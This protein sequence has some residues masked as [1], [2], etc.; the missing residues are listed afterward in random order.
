MKH[1]DLRRIDLNLLVTFDALM[2]TRS[3]TRAAERLGLGQPAVSHALA[4]LRD[5]TG[6]SLFVSSRQGLVPTSRALSIAGWVRSVLEDAQQKLL[7]PAPFNPAEWAGTV[8][9]SMTPKMD[10]LLMPRLLAQLAVQAPHVRVVVYAAPIWHKVVDQLDDGAVDLYV[11]FTGELKAWHRQRALWKENLLALFSSKQLRRFLPLTLGSYLACS[12]VLVTQQRGVWERQVD[13]ALAH[14]GH[15]RR[16]VLTTPHFF[17]IPQL[18]LETPLIATM[19]GRAA[20][21][22]KRAFKLMTS[23]VPIEITSFD[24]SL[25]WHEVVD[26]DPAQRW[27]RQTILDVAKTA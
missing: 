16:V 20:R 15:Q 14:I 3:V 1:F 21:W 22:F 10:M 4:R 12:H 6:D 13:D 5:V 27:L 8:R 19:H 24:E 25:V 11:G 23:P 18:L 2:T 17:V 9:L 7:E 26:G